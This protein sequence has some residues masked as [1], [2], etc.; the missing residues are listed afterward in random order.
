MKTYF[1]QIVSHWVNNPL[2]G[3]G[4]CPEIH[5]QH[6]TDSRNFWRIFISF[7]MLCQGFL[8]FF[9][10]VSLF[11]TGPFHIYY[12]FWFCVFIEL[13]CVGTCVFTCFLSFSFSSFSFGLFYTTLWFVCFYLILFYYFFLDSCFIL[14]REQVW[15][16][17]VE[18]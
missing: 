15:I 13:L 18:K 1:S 12:G 6:K 3:P 8:V 7:I 11:F 5:S 9:C 14:L 2:L 4:E 10:F 16:W 17:V